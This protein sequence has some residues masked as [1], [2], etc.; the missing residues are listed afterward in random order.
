[1]HLD[2]RDERLMLILISLG[3]RSLLI[4]GI[5]LLATC[6]NSPSLTPSL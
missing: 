3:E 5:S 4:S 2:A 1:M 6:A